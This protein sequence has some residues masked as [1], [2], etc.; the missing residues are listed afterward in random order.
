MTARAV[1]VSAPQA[2]DRLFGG[3][4]RM[5]L[6][7]PFR[8]RKL[9]E[10]A[11]DDLADRIAEEVLT[12]A[13]NGV[14]A[15]RGDRRFRQVVEAKPLEAH[16]GRPGPL[17]EGA[18]YL[19]TGGLGGLGLTTAE[20]LARVAKAK[21]VLLGRTPLPPRDQ[22]TE[23]MRQHGA[24]DRIS[25]R[26]RRIL[27]VEE[28]GGEVMV[29]SADVTNVEEMRSAIGR[30]QE[31]FGRIRGV[32]HTAGV[33]KDDL[34]A[35]KTQD[36][37][38]DVFTPK[39]QGTRV[40]AELF[41]DEELDVMVLFSSTSTATAPAGQVDYVAAN[42]YLD[43]FA[44]SRAHLRTRTVSVH[45]GIWAEVGM[46]A[47]SLTVDHAAEAGT[48]VGEQP[49]HPLLHSR[50]K[51]MRGET[52]LRAVYSPSKQWILDGHRTGSG[53]AL[54]RAPATSSSPGPRCAPTARTSPLRSRTSSSSARSRSPTAPSGRSA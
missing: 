35:L 36:S 32:F 37:V 46:A 54:I 11:L 7:D 42:A 12:P 49:T 14:I 28:A 26:I 3:T 24:E 16:E 15:W 6:V 43:A 31:K 19:I 29:V 23:W 45:W 27:D 1:D 33:V 18:A 52:E 25:R 51:D 48:P 30:A 40:L 8:G 9:M 41:D 38:E 47:E 22:W 39:I 10:A 50:T 44:E 13:D 2:S 4:L 5:A 17:R 20:W 21:L 53:N 34:I